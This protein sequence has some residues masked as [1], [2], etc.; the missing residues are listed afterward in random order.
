[1]DGPVTVPAESPFGARIGWS[2]LPDALRGWVEQ[3]LAGPVVAAH[4]QHGGFSPGTADRVVTAAGARAFVKAVSAAQNPDTPSLLRREA[5]VLGRLPA[6]VGAPRLIGCQDVD[7]WTVLV[8][9]DIEGRH[10]V[11]PWSDADTRAAFAIL[12]RLAG[13]SDPAP[14]WL[15]GLEDEVGE[16]L[17]AWPR[18]GAGPADLLDPW[19]AGRLDELA[20]RSAATAARLRGDTVVHVDVRADNLLVQPD[21]VARLVDWPWAARGCP[22]F[23]A[24]S[25]LVNLRLRGS[26]DLAAYLPLVHDLGATPDDVV[27][28]VAGMA[29][30]FV[31]AG[32]KPAVPGLPAL[33]AFQRAQGVAAVAVLRELLDP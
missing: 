12:T 28:V 8:T 1:M 22:W 14:D 27:G 3:L 33:R 17:S 2:E 16:L 19:A 30:Y 18:L 10:P 29:G 15:P 9:E 32:A 24:A 13:R 21:G 25:L 20:A 6:D 4:G 11:Q 31:E 26:G 7:G 23:D 5:E